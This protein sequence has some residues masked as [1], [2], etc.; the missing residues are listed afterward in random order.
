MGSTSR[1][2]FEAIPW[3]GGV[4]CLRV[5]Q[6]GD[7]DPEHVIDGYWSSRIGQ[8]FKD[9]DRE[10]E[11]MFAGVGMGRGWGWQFGKF[12]DNRLERVKNVVSVGGRLACPI[13]YIG[14]TKSLRQRM[15]HLLLIE[16]TVNHPLWALLVAGW[17]LA[18]GTRACPAHRDEE[19]RLKNLYRSTHADALPAL[20]DR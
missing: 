18:L 3:E 14:C 20:M 12:A 19:T 7:P 17:S 5:E 13:V 16:H 1:D 2:G 9:L 11:E 8:A 6:V 4:Y 10:S 15:R